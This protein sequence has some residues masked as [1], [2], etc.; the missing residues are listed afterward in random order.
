M[1]I[2]LRHIFPAFL[3]NQKSVAKKIFLVHGEIERQTSFKGYLQDN[4]F[5]HTEIDIPRLGDEV[6]ING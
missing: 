6:E 4:G 1:S 3:S 5:V 2:V